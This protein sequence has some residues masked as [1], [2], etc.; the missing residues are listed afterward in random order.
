MAKR[1]VDSS[2]SDKKSAPQHQAG[3]W[4]KWSNVY[5]DPQQK[6]AAKLFV[7]AD[8][9]LDSYLATLLEDG[10]TL[11]FSYNEETE[12]SI[13]TI[14]GKRCGGANEGWGMTTH[15]GDWYTAMCRALYK[16]FVLGSDMSFEEMGK[17]YANPLT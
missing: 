12:S 3:T 8:G 1:A 11:G 16:H 17:A 6:E 2:K 15:A 10:Y 4:L 9:K 13:C 5:L 7:A 14:I